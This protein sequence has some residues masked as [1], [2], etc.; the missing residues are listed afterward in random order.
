M[1]TRKSEHSYFCGFW[2]KIIVSIDKMGE[3]TLMMTH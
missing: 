3:K 2:Q 1:E